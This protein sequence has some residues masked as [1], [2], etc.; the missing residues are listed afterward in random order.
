VSGANV[1]DPSEPSEQRLDETAPDAPPLTRTTVRGAQL[2]GA[3]WLLSQVLMFAAFVVLARLLT[4]SDF[5]QYAAATVIT[6]IGGLFSESGM[7][8]ALI[9]RRDRLEEAA[10]TAFVSLLVGGCL[11]TLASLALAPLIGVFF[12]SSRIGLVTAAMSGWLFLRALTVVPDALLQRRFS[13]AR[14]VAIDPLGVVAYAAISIPLASSGA[15]VWSLVAGAY[16]SMTLQVAAAWI[17][18]RFRPRRKL[19]S[20]ALWRRELAPYSRAIIGAEMLRRVSLQIDAFMLGRFGGTAALGQY[21]NG[22]RVAGQPANAFVSVAAYVLLPAFARISDA[23]ER[24]RAAALRVHRLVIAAALPV[25]FAALPLGV[26]AAVLLLGSRWRPAGHAIA[27][28]CG[29]ILGTIVI[30]YAS[31][32]YKSVRRPG[33]LVRVHFVGFV[34]IAVTVSTAAVLW[35]LVAVAIAMSVSSFLTAIYALRLV[36]ALLEISGREL[37]LDAL[38]PLTATGAMLGAMLLFGQGLSPLS[39]ARA[40]ALALCAA[41]A[42]VGAIAY[43]S[44]L[45]GIDPRRRAELRAWASCQISPRN[46]AQR[47]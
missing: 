37:V 6:G 12:R 19:A 17:F 2:A 35:G 46:V 36:G 28:L 40:V 22:L 25:S 45:F 4:P 42:V 9:N 34:C 44:V 38:G 39:H 32:I 7:L 11:L 15:G 1:P 33:L 47:G 27:A 10:S 43:I 14:R 20:F 41:E 31:E 24:M 8:A 13:F 18:A 30:S 3:G 5:G 29:F 23:K 21:R 16:G 26:P